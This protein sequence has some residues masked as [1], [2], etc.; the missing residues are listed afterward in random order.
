MGQLEQGSKEGLKRGS[1]R[2]AVLVN[3]RLSCSR[4]ACCGARPSLKQA[5]VQRSLPPCSVSNGG[6]RLATIL[7]YLSTPEEGGETGQQPLQLRRQL[8]TLVA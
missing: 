2:T 1:A 6:N 7:M 3:D 4:R 5:G 8:R